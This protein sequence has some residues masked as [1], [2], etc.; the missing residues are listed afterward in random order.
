MAVA[1][2][3]ALEDGRRGDHL[4]LDREHGRVG[5]RLRRRAPG[6]TTVVLCPAGA[7]AAGEARAVAR[8]RRARA[9]GAGQLRRGAPEL[10]RARR[11]RRAS[12]SSTRSTPTGSRGR[13]PPRSRSSRSSG[14]RPTC[15]RSPTAAAATPSPTRRAS[16]RRARA[17]RLLAGAGGGARGDDR[18]GDPDRRAGAR[19]T[20]SSALV[21][22][23][24][25]DR[26]ASPTTRSSPRGSSSRAARASSASRPRPPAS[27]RSRRSSS[28][29]GS[30]V[31]CVLTGHGL[32]DTAAVDGSTRRD[33]ARRADGRRDPRR[34]L[35]D[36][37]G[38][39]CVVRAPASTANLGPGFDCAA[40]ALD[41]WNELHVGPAVE[42][43]PLDRARRRGSRRASARRRRISRCARSRSW[44]RSTATA[45]ASSTGSR[46]SAGS[47]RRAATVAAGL[48]AGA[49][50]GRPARRPRT[51]CS[52]S[53]CR[54]KGTPTTSPPRSAGGVCLIWRERRS[55]RTRAGSRPTCRSRRSSSSPSTRVNTTQSRVAAC[56]SSCATT[57]PS[58][59][60][61]SRRC[62][63]RRSPPATRGLLAEAFHDRLHEPF[64]ASRRA[65]AR[66][67]AL[68]ARRRARPA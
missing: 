33:P 2:A 23:G 36:E 52:S 34:G 60:P 7:I 22:A 39:S 12:R 1:V 53:G 63:A 16:T 35:V 8:G 3:K 27:P 59:R 30:T 15:S 29:P 46:S 5:R 24:R 28:S 11:A 44:R 41:L 10:P 51:S 21:A 64:R 32:K 66:R 57:R 19:S 56:P 42:G 43:E 47:A 68:A 26:D 9:R 62:S 45:S 40:A 54:S 25:R 58:P 4:R 48:V 38:E 61:R 18:L 20:R 65:A 13:R 50:R 55:R 14:A 6:S 37:R 67:V 31:V 17:P 49:R